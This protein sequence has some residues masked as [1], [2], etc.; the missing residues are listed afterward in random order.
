MTAAQQKQQKKQSS[1][2]PLQTLVALQGEI[3]GCE[4]RLALKHAAVNR[5]R[6]LVPAGHILWLSFRGSKVKIDAISSQAHV[7]TTSPFIQWMGAQLEDRL[8]RGELS[9][10]CQFDLASRRAN[11]TFSY[12][13]HQACFAPFTGAG[14][15]A[16]GGLLFTRETAFEDTEQALISRL[17]AICGTAWQAH[18]AKKRAV[19][20]PRKKLGVGL[21]AAALLLAAIIPVP[22]TILAPAEITAAS[23]Y[24][25]TAPIDGV[26]EQILVPPNTVVKKGTPLVRLVDT[27]FH[28]EYILA[29][30]EE[31][32]AASKL[33]K[34][35]LTA[36]VDE[37]AKR[38]IAIAK[39]EKNLAVARKAYARDRLS[40]TTLIAPRDGLAIFSKPQDWTGRPVAIGEAIMQIADPSRVLLRIDAPLA[41]GE[42]LQGGARVRLFLDSN[43][44][45]AIE[46]KLGEASYYAEA[47]PDGTQA[48]AAF[49]AL[50]KPHTPRIGSRG[51]AKIY[52]R[53]APLGFWLARKP[54]TLFRQTTG[55]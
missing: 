25:L 4:D 5:P 41:S 52:G 50:D 6:K 46:A 24:I 45:R 1:A 30:G 36:F 53:T 42:V 31:T 28:N 39:A 49:A 13:F 47:A 14:G 44:L 23:P 40:K 34:A 9:Q 35:G 48:F 55:L 26:I 29:E 11:D 3:L 51:V 16:G 22:M 32:V 18:S 19:M 15:S 43:P 38:D 17:A 54:I 20:T 10:A 21:T 8:R 2:S 12:P 27:S 37:A 33:R 7:E